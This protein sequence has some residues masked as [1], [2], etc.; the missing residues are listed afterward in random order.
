VRR[1][2][3]AGRGPAYLLLEDGGT[4]DEAIAALLHDSVEDWDRFSAPVEGQ[5][6]YFES[7]VAMF[8]E[9]APGPMADELA[10]VVAEI[11]GRHER[12]APTA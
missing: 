2:R 9:R 6:W 12:A 3:C 7:L 11:K 8:R 1:T 4:E 5:P 10:E